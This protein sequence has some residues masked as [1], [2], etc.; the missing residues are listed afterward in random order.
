MVGHSAI[1]RVVMGEEATA[2]E[3]KP[4]ELEAMQELLRAG[5]DAGA[6]GFSSSW[7]RTHNDAE[8]HMVPSRFATRDELV[9]LCSTLSQYEGTSLEFIPMVGPF[10]PWAV[11]LMAAMSAGGATAAQLERARRQRPEPQRS[12]A[13]ARGRRPTPASTAA[14]SSRSPCP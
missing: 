8:G 14:A 5:L 12:R 3:S 6:L 13:E 11:E 9:D 7:A 1:R 4:E 10:E 2:R